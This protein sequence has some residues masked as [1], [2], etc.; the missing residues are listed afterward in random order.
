MTSPLSA[1]ASRG[2]GTNALFHKPAR[3]IPALARVLPAAV[4][5]GNEPFPFKNEVFLVRNE[6]FLVRNEVFLVRNES[7]L[8]KNGLE[9]VMAA[10]E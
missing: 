9:I 10:L 2:A 6:S 4:L 8:V 1:P 3:R 7:F 5:H